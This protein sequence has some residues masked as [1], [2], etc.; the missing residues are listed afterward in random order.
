[1]KE[2]IMTLIGYILIWT[3]TDVY[4]LDLPNS[5]K[6]FIKLILIT[7]GALIIKHN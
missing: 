7:S 6:W 4:K 5:A 1:M 3:S 2:L